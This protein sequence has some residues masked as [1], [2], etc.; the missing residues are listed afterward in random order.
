[1]KKI[2]VICSTERE[3]RFYLALFPEADRKKF[4][5]IYS[6]DQL[7]GMEFIEVLSMGTVIDSPGYDALLMK[8]EE[9]IR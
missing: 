8:A 3:F 6:E 4:V 5:R 2:A 1:M 9:R 7:R